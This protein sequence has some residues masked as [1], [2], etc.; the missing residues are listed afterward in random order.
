MRST[1]DSFLTKKIKSSNTTTYDCDARSVLTK[2]WE[3]YIDPT[4]L[5]YYIY[6]IVLRYL[7]TIKYIFFVHKIGD[8]LENYSYRASVGC[9]TLLC[10]FALR[11]VHAAVP[12]KDNDHQRHTINHHNKLKENNS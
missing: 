3:V 5:Y 10:P 2:L 9:A 8:T 1:N 6:H 11:T 4:T 7:Q 12:P